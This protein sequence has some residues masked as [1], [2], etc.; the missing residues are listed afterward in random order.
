MTVTLITGADGHVGKA[1]ANSLLGHSN[2]ELLLFVRGDK[3][4]KL[5]ALAENKRCRII[6]G[7]LRDA[8]PFSAVDGNQVTGILHCAA[9]TNFAVDRKTAQDVNVDGTEKLIRFAD[10]CPQLRRFGL[11][12]S[13][14]AAGLRDGV[15]AEEACDNSAPFA[16]HYEWSKWSA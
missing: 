8:Q 6:Q 4:G 5:G 2:D 11:V 13:L 1:L 12:S 16:N 7:D 3:C 14:Y 10:D 15:I 9:V